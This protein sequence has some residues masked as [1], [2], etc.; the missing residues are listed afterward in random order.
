MVKNVTE[1]LVDAEM[2][3]A[4]VALLLEH[5]SRLEDDREPQ[6][7][8]YPLSE[9]LL[10]V[11][12]A[13]IASCDDFDE[14]EAW[15][16]HHL[17]FLRQFAPFHFGIPCDR[18]LRTLINRV[19]PIL[20]GRC[21][22][23]WIKALWPGRHELIAIDGKT[24]RRTHDKGK[25][26][27]AL[28]TLSAYATNAQLTLAQLS[29]PDKTNEITAIPDLLDRLAGTGQLKGALVTIDAMGCQVAIA[30]KIVAHE[31]DFLL[32]LKGNQLILETE[33]DEYFR[34][35]PDAELVRKTTIEKGRIETRIYTASTVVDWIKSAKSYPEQPKFNHIKTLVKVVNRT[36][37]KDRCT[38]DERLYISSA[39]LD[40]ERIAHGVRGHWGVESMHWL[41][42]V[43]FKDDLS[44]YRT[45]HGAKNMAVVRRFALGLVRADKAK[46]SVK[47]KRKSASWSMDALTCILQLK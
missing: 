39:P 36:E 10:L 16:T 14:I 40:I 8:M 46:G 20:F 2:P 3:R 24:S 29:V 7:V 25:G 13:T 38:L 35:A 15:G 6:R 47:T 28:H 1:F 42:D 44:R 21:F 12:C 45:G 11:S 18:W 32:A 9:V 22:E 23:D 17:E 30:D 5:F 26:L 37:L 27:K 41:L 43:A 34:T 19:D 4:R 31:A 33:V